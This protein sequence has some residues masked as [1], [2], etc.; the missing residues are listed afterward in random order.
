MVG[1]HKFVLQGSAFRI[2][3]TAART[4]AVCLLSIGLFG[5]SVLLSDLTTRIAMARIVKKAPGIRIPTDMTIRTE[6]RRSFTP[7]KSDMRMEGRHRATLDRA[8]ASFD[9]TGA[10]P[11][12]PEPAAG[13]AM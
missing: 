2:R 11:K 10:P 7:L 4:N 6:F 5:R 13:G 8:G 3:T 1:A 9:G 12:G